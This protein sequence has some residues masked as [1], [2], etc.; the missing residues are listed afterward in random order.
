LD[1]SQN[2]ALQK[3]K[4]ID[5]NTVVMATMDNAIILFDMKKKKIIYKKQLNLASFSDFE[6]SPDATK[7]AFVK[8]ESGEI[9]V[10]DT[11]TLEEE[12]LLYGHKQT[13]IKIDFHTNNEL[14]TA[15]E[16]NKL[17]FWKL[18]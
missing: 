9:S 8:N 6:L 10:I 1:E 5:A 2:L 15:D 16:A 3:I 18:E 4:F 17:M 14:I 13:I 11:K 12:Y 7:A